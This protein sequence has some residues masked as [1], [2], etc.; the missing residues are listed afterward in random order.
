MNSKDFILFF[1]DFKKILSFLFLVV[2]LLFIK[3]FLASDDKIDVVVKNITQQNIII[4]KDASNKKYKISLFG[5]SNLNLKKDELANLNKYLK[6]A[7][8]NKNINLLI[9]SKDKFGKIEAIVIL[10]DIDFN[11]LLVKKGYVFANLQYSDAYINEQ[12]YARKHKLG[13]WNI[14]K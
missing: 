10:N 4:A 5:V 2:V 9:K 14:K 13:I 6:L 3:F 12:E 1:K 8:L 11:S 7:L